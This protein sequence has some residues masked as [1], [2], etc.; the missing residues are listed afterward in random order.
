MLK[1][2][3]IKNFQS[4]Q[5]TKIDFCPG[6][7]GVIGLSQAGKT[8]ILRAF[9]LL[10]QNRPLGR[11]FHNKYT[12]ASKTSVHAMFSNNIIA[13]IHKSKKETKYKLKNISGEKISFSK[14][15]KAVPDLISQNINLSK[16][17]V[18]SQ[19][20][21]PFMVISSPGEIA[22]E[23]NKITDS[24]MVDSWTSALNK[25]IS[26]LKIKNEI[27]K[28]RLRKNIKEKNKYKNLKNADK[29]IS[30]WEKLTKK[31]KTKED[32]HFSLTED[33]EKI[34]NKKRA[35]LS[36]K[37]YSAIEKFIEGIEKVKK[38][39]KKIEQG[40]YLLKELKQENNELSILTQEYKDLSRKYIQKIKS[41]KRCPV[42]LHSIKSKDIKRIQNEIKIGNGSI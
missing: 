36:L 21:S 30:R 10:R 40:F 12:K 8:S 25:E 38:R 3:R 20:D 13:S 5:N 14:V 19:L 42:C 16:I 34:K 28:D 11:R 1:Q 15:G 26:K 22:R 41:S 32:L 17:N 18:Q 9:K 24:E 4:H 33:N 29:I 23:I 7:N 6:V 37:K 27:Q 39:R 31:R 2:L 35:I